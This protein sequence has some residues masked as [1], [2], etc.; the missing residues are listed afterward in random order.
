MVLLRNVQNCSLYTWLYGDTQKWHIE[1]IMN[2][3]IIIII[4]I[5]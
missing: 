2:D 1:K 5:T 3:D 4:I